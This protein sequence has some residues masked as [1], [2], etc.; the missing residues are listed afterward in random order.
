LIEEHIAYKK[1]C[2]FLKHN[3]L[4][5]TPFFRPLFAFD[6]AGLLIYDPAEES[7]NMRNLSSYVLSASL[8][9]AIF[10][11][12]ARAQSPP[13]SAIVKLDPN[14]DQILSPDAKL[15]LLQGE[16]SFEGGE[17]PLW[18]QKGNT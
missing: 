17:G 5:I 8:A 12:S 9:I 3:S 2:P 14:L 7:I 6:V 16:G 13:A 1:G 11:L 10:C 15:E 18:I 4:R